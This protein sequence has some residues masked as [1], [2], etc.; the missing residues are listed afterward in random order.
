MKPVVTLPSNFSFDRIS[1]PPL[2]TFEIIGDKL[3]FIEDISQSELDALNTALSNYDPTTP[4]PEEIIDQAES[5]VA[6][7]RPVAQYYAFLTMT[8]AEF[9]AW[10]AANSAEDAFWVVIV[11]LRYLIACKNRVKAWI[12][13]N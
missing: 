1:L 10:Y 7:L 8:R 13:R 11:V 9:S 4:T 12:G 3:R 5:D 2:P 6:T